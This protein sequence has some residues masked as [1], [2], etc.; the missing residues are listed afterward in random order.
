[1]RTEEQI[2][3]INNALLIAA[4][5]GVQSEVMVSALNAMRECP[6]LTLEE[7]VQYGLDEWVK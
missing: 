1:M 3:I 4:E 7:A 5:Y 2:A 6:G